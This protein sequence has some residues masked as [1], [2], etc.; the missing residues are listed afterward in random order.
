[1]IKQKI[2]KILKQQL[3][4]S[5]R[6]SPVLMAII[7]GGLAAIGLA[8]NSQ[9]TILGSMLLSPIGSLINKSNLYWLLKKNNIKLERKYSY[10]FVPLLFVILITILVSYIF[11]LIFS[12]L[13]NP[14]TKEKL[15]K[16]WP[17]KEMLDRANP[18]N[19][20]Y[21]IFIALLCGIALPISIIMNSGVRFVAIGIATAL[22]PPLANIGLA[23][24]LD[25]DVS[26]TTSL[27]TNIVDKTGMTYKQR[28]IFVGAS[29]FIINM[30]L[31][32]FPSRYLLEV[33]VK[34][35]N[36]F[37][38]TEVVLNDPS[39]AFGTKIK[40]KKRIN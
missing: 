13:N 32:Y 12:R 16:E 15:T 3:D 26:K 4:E 19:S 40:K 8:T 31:L 33:F 35:N 24:S 34:K 5:H 20:I 23:L 36:F 11:G 2:I 18:I 22:I 1:M 7:A 28:A 39:T 17:T 6:S 25:N 10:W 9:T 21:M 27:E 37:Y 14:F 38:K 29:I 30:L